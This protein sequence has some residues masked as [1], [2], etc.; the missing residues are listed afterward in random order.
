MS[1]NNID[2][3]IKTAASLSIKYTGMGKQNNST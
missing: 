1:D 3:Q 2:A